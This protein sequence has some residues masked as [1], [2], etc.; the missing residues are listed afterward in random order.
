MARARKLY[1]SFGFQR[2]SGPMGA[3]GHFAVDAWYARDLTTLDEPGVD[4]EAASTSPPK[5]TN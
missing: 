1:E 2:L 4:A 5:K 3:T